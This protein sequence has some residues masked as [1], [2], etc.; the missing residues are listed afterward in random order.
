ME[1][2]IDIK[3]FMES[4]TDIKKLMESGTNILISRNWWNQVL[5]Y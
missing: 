4:G 5:I 1:S 2:G 3:K